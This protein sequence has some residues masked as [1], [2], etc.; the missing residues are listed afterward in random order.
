MENQATSADVQIAQWQ[1]FR[2]EILSMDK[3]SFRTR[4]HFVLGRREALRTGW[5]VSQSGGGQPP[6]ISQ[7]VR[8]WDR[9]GK[10]KGEAR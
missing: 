7:E 5:C 9:C 2:Q 10:A 4:E 6:K 1:I 8:G 3:S